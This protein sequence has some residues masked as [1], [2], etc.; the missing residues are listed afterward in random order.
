[1]TIRNKRRSDL[2]RSLRKSPQVRLRFYLNLHRLIQRHDLHY[3]HERPMIFASFLHVANDWFRDIINRYCNVK[4]RLVD[5]VPAFPTS[6]A[7]GMFHVVESLVNLLRKI[8]WILL[9]R[10]I[11]TA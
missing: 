10:A 4:A 3:S 11:P 1:M 6:L 2:L 8:F 7:N 9:G 5:L